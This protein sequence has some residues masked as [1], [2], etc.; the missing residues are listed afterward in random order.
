MKENDLSSI[1]KYWEKEINTCILKEINTC[2]LVKNLMV[3][4]A[5]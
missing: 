5:R 2:I 1:N 4:V 3:I